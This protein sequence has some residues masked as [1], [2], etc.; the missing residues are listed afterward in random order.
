MSG[1]ASDKADRDGTDD[2]DWDE[3]EEGLFAL[4]PGATIIDAGDYEAGRIVLGDTHW[5]L[6]IPPDGPEAR[7]L[8]DTT[9]QRILIT[10]VGVLARTQSGPTGD[11]VR[12]AD[13]RAVPVGRLEAM[14]NERTL[15]AHIRQVLDVDSVRIG[16]DFSPDHFDVPSEVYRREEMFH[17]S[18]S[19]RLMG[20]D[21]TPRPDGFYSDVA[22]LWSMALIH[23]YRNPAVTIAESN[24][25]T[26]SVVHRWARKARKL[27]YLAPSSRAAQLQPGNESKAKIE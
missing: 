3:E 15:A 19:F 16:R 17:S 23:G 14:V 24:G 11:S 10:G 8:L 27:G 20:I 4:K 26:T 9:G 21:E 25:V 5:I 7:I 12:A 18:L 22:D 1:T 13:L 2:P 6:W